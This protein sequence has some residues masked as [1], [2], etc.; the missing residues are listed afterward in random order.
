MGLP[1]R[2]VSLLDWG[3]SPAALVTYGQNLGGIAVI[4]QAAKP[5]C[6]APGPERWRQAGPEP[7]DVTINGATGQELDTP[8]GTVLQFSRGGVDYTVLGSVPAGGG[9]R[10]GTRAMTRER[11]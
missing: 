5:A 2:S 7:A 6:R 8:L 4:E 10:G 11:S 9:R 3:G 1:R